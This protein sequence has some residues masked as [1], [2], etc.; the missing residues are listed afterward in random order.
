M[1]KVIDM[2]N[3]KYGH[4]LVI[5]R[6]ED[7]FTPKGH[8]EIRWWCKCDCGN[9]DLVLVRGY[10]LRR[11]TTTSCGCEQKKLVSERFKKYNTYDL[12]GD[13]GI[14]YTSKGEEFYFDLEDYDKIKDYCWNISRKYVVAAKLDDYTKD[15]YMHNI[16]MDNEEDSGFIVDHIKHKENDNRKSQLRIVNSSQNQINKVKQRNNTSGVPGV[17]WDKR[18]QKWIAR[19]NIEKNKRIEIG[20][21]SNF[22]EAVKM[23]KEAEE[24]Y[25]GEFSYEN[26]MN[27]DEER[28]A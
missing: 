25:Y 14:G 27:Y 7:Y 17:T 1:G 2:T 19:I 6:G 18:K 21:S 20:H 13:F 15:I 23:R 9:P 22:D 11:G 16:V 26:S 10:C 28:G 3:Q 4:L 5:K 24:K 12:S 8:K